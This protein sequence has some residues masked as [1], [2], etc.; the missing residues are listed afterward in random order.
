MQQCLPDGLVQ[1]QIIQV[2]CIAA[3]RLPAEQQTGLPPVVCDQLRSHR[4]VVGAAAR[5]QQLALPPEVERLVEP[6]QHREICPGSNAPTLAGKLVEIIQQSQI[7]LAG[8]R[9]LFAR[10]FNFF[11]GATGQRTAKF[12][13]LLHG[14]QHI[15]IAGRLPE[16][17]PTKWQPVL[18]FR[19]K[20]LLKKDRLRQLP[21]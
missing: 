4:L 18:D 11:S 9:K 20:I 10:L 3:N 21:E 16:T 15:G 19:T 7:A 17:C 5:H 1:H 6:R 8:Y 12:T 2:P 14:I 13:H